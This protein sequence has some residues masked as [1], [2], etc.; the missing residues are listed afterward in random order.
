MLVHSTFNPS[1]SLA[2]FGRYR[3]EFLS[4]EG[5]YTIKP[6]IYYYDTPGEEHYT[7]EPA[8]RTIS[9]LNGKATDV[10]FTAKRIRVSTNVALEEEGAKTSASS[11]LDDD[12]E[13]E[14]VIDDFPA[15]DGWRTGSGGWNDGTPN[16]F[17]DWIEVNFGRLRRINWMNVFTLPDDYKNPSEP[18][19]KQTQSRRR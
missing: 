2:D 1:L 10:N 4:E 6:E 18:D 9:I 5:T 3:I 12:F 14:N 16:V 15:A 13:T 8:S 17:P 7:I 11:I 19:L